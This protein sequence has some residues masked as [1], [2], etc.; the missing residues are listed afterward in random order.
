MV[1]KGMLILGISR[2]ATGRWSS[3]YI[4]HNEAFLGRQKLVPFFL[5]TQ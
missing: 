1:K 4:P 3:T 2:R 5:K